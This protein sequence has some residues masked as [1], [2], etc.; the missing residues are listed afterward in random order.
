MYHVSAQGVDERMIKCT[1]LLLLSWAC[2]CRG[3]SV[4][5]QIDRLA[6]KATV[7]GGL[8]LGRSEMLRSLRHCTCGH[9]ARGITLSITWRRET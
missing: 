9:R 7:T 3:N 8:R 4:T 5:E 1:L 2:R 6:G